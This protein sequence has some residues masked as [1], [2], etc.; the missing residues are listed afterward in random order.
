MWKI[1]TNAHTVSASGRGDPV[2]LVWLV[3]VSPQTVD[4]RNL[5]TVRAGQPLASP[6]FN[7]GGAPGTRASTNKRQNTQD[8]YYPILNVGGARGDIKKVA[9]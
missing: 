5:A 1:T 7:I 2:C 4:G 6:T 3:C 8:I 9:R